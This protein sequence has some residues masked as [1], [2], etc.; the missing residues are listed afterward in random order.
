MPFF[1][2]KRKKLT[3]LESGKHNETGFFVVPLVTHKKIEGE[4]LNL[5]K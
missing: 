1:L 5:T 3:L 2:V 4:K